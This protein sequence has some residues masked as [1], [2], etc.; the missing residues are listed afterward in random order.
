MLGE[1]KRRARSFV[2]GLVAVLALAVAAP[3]A[4]AGGFFSPTGPWNAPIVANPQL[5][6]NSPLIV[7]TLSNSIASKSSASPPVHPYFATS[8]Y[9][10]PIYYVGAGA[11]KLPLKIEPGNF[12]QQPLQN[13]INGNGGVPFPANAEQSS[14]T[15]GHITVYDTSAKQ[16]YEF[17]HA[18]TPGM[19][20]PG[21][22]PLPWRG[23]PPCY[24]DSK[25]HADW[26]GIMDQVDTDPGF[27]SVNSWPGL[28]GTQGYSW[29]STA[30]SLPVVA[31]T[32]TF[33][34]LDAGVIDHALA[35]AWGNTCKNYFS[36]PAQR[37][38]GTDLNDAACLA[39]GAKLQLD[40]AYDVNANNHP[41][42]TKAVERAAQRYGIIVRDITA[43][44]SFQFYGQDPRTESPNPYTSGPGVGGIDSGGKGYFGGL[45]PSSLFRQ[46]PWDRLRVIKST[47]CTA[48]PCI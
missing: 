33:E 48:P 6:L 34:E 14:G 40:P 3:A 28:T 26:G 19:N 17:W 41:P 45:A 4:S 12:G 5:E 43:G 8:S 29:G 21:C 1:G 35:A 42:L 20:A 36:A 37:R 10:T 47:H 31:G 11:P 25:W 2:A 39:E 13:A 30:T 46:F 24:G 44:G 9:S 23:N 38:D 22:G 15:D 16:L 32:V 18:S 27:Y 7:T